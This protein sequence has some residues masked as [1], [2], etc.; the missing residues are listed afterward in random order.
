MHGDRPTSAL[1]VRKLRAKWLILVL[2][3]L[4]FVTSTPGISRADDSLIES[5]EVS[6]PAAATDDDTYW[7]QARPGVIPAE[8]RAV[9]KAVIT[10]QKIDRVGTHLY[11]GL[12]AMWSADL[13]KTWT[14]PVAIQS[15]DRFTRPDG[16]LDAP[17]DMTPQWHS[18]S[19][20]LLVTGVTFLQDLKIKRNV[21]R[22]PS[23]IA[24]T[25]YDAST[26]QWSER[27]NVKMP[28]ERKFFF[29]RAGCTQ[30][31]DLPDGDVLLPIYFYSKGAEEVNYVT[32][33]RCGFDGETL[34]YREHGSELTVD[35]GAKRDR[36]GLYEPSLTFFGGKYLLTLRADEGAYV[37]VS[38][39]GLHFSE[40]KPW[41]FDD[42]KL[43]GSYNTQQHWVTHSDGL[44]VSYTRRGAN[45]DHIMRHRAPLFIAR[46]DPERLVVERATEQILLPN[47][48]A[49]FGNFGVCN[50][51][52]DE[53]WV[54][55]CLVGAKP[56]ANNVYLA[57]IRWSRPNQMVVSA[58]RGESRK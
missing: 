48:G 37:S 7:M 18:K 20:K 26:G 10:L 15:A 57:K 49:A 6:N 28:D 33:L 13:G 21:P 38:D 55:D 53:T 5:I 46:V 14:A 39:D 50:V 12:A 4:M 29:A 19:G 58:N 43:L 31:V 42:G 44:Y 16:L 52:P 11:H 34:S 45:N 23:E 27:R 40:S 36:T 25:V 47:L 54:V 22:G 30:R 35:L 9:P 24:Y 56:G 3:L 17:A 32:V 1:S 41:K 51:T 8:G 2:P